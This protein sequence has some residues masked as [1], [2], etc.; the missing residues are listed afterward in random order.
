MN[1][2]WFDSW[3]ET[4]FLLKMILCFSELWVSFLSILPNGGPFPKRFFRVQ[5]FFFSLTSVVY[6]TGMPWQL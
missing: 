2:S 6:D 4:F 5:N 3:V 1:N